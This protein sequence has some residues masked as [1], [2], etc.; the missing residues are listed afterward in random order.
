MT[1]ASIDRMSLG[2]LCRTVHFAQGDVLRQKGQHYTDMYL[3]VE[4]S[5][6]VDCQTNRGRE[7]V[8]AGA[9]SPIGEIGFLRGTSAS[10]T[11]AAKT[12]T[13]ALIL[14]ASTRACLEQQQPV[15][16][17]QVFRQL[18]LIAEERTSDNLRFD[19][20][21]FGP[22]AGL[23][24]L[25]CQNNQM[26]QSAQRLRYT[27]Y[28]DELKRRSPYADHA[29][30]IIADDLDKAGHTFVAVEKGET[31]GTVRLNL[32]SEGPLGVL[33]G[34][35]GMNASKRHPAATAVCTKFIV[36]KSK[37]GGPTALALISAVARYGIRHSIQ[38]AYIDCVPALLP[39]Y[40]AI[41]F[42]VAGD[43]F[44]HQENGL[45]HPMMLDVL[46]HGKRLSKERVECLGVMVRA[47]FFKLMDGVRRTA[48]VWKQ[49]VGREP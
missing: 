5:V 39:Y 2:S 29:K 19:P 43:A 6:A 14:D 48:Q 22:A 26:L 45:S 15:L 30:K 35:Y 38:E 9:G 41:G 23:D 11:V 24:I 17:E 44:L 46:K 27:V 13:S 31:I 12:A 20:T 18:A 40:Q 1:Q 21:A 36:R 37:R 25:L 16:T 32:S 49:A 4:G 8:V 28:C 42:T 3:L 10:A 7:L 34:L 47:Q 33:E